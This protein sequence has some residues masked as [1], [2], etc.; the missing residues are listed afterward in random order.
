MFDYNFCSQI[1]LQVDSDFECVDIYKQ[2]SLQHPLLKNH[3][4]QV[5]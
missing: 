2:P 4:I 1:Q 5:L 3:K